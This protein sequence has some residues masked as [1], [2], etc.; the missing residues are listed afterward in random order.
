MTTAVVLSHGYW[1]SPETGNG[2]ERVVVGT[3][4]T[5]VK[6]IQGFDFSGFQLLIGTGELERNGDMLL[7]RKLANAAMRDPASNWRNRDGLDILAGADVIEAQNT[8]GEVEQALDICDKLRANF[9][10]VVH[11]PEH[12][13]AYGTATAL[14]RKADPALHVIAS[15]GPH[16][17]D[18]VGGPLCVEGVHMMDEARDAYA[19]FG[20]L[21]LRKQ[22]AAE[23][24]AFKGEELARYVLARN[25]LRETMG[26][27]KLAV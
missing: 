11:R 18:G 13:R 2:W 14:A 21:D 1:G 15:A 5:A 24:L 23:V 20:N 19:Q 26:L 10:L 4:C 6:L 25:A 7:S 9:L 27:A 8:A 16:D 17:F 12:L 3:I 22:L